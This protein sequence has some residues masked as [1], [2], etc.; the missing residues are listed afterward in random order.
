MDYTNN[1]HHHHYYYSGR[2]VMDEKQRHY[3]CTMGEQV[4]C[5]FEQTET[6]R[7]RGRNK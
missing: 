6:E 2:H 3:H 1:H 7:E 5:H 4:D